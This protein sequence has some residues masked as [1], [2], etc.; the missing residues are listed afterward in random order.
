MLQ[1]NVVVTFAVLGM[2][3]LLEYSAVLV[4]YRLFL[5]PLTGFVRSKNAA[6]THYYEFD[7]WCQGKYIFEIEKM[8]ERYGACIRKRE[9]EGLPTL[10]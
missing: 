9:A 7:G 4:A 8:H 1:E 2:L 3:C 10:P 5:S 6:A